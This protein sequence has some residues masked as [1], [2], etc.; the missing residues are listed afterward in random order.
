VPNKERL[1][2][3]RDL[4]AQTGSGQGQMSVAGSCI[5][6]DADGYQA[7]LR[8]MCD[9]LVVCPRRFHARL[10]WVELPH[11][12]LMRAEESSARIAYLR[13]PPEQ[14][15]VFIATHQGPALMHGGK[16]VRFGDLVWHSQDGKGHQRTTEGSR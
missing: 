2:F 10:T 15:F 5:F 7:S 3:R 14:V 6:T 12:R 11:V 9:L 4:D 1:L 8:D 13:L 16:E